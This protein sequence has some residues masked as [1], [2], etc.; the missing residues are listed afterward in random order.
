MFRYDGVA[1]ITGRNSAELVVRN[2]KWKLS[3]PSHERYREITRKSR[4]VE[5]FTP[6]ISA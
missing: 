6:V 4:E 2:R 5:P 3:T 1:K